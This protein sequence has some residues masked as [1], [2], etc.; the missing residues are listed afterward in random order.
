MGE[1]IGVRVRGID[2]P[3]ITDQD[4]KI[5]QN[6]ILAKEY[7]QRRLTTAKT[8][9]LKN[10]ERD[11]YFRILADVEVD[12]VSLSRELLAKGLAKPYDGG[13]KEQW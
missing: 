1:R 7:V 10:I 5:K 2:T 4:P 8:I 9:I 3:E 6:A 13:T 11:K 12:D